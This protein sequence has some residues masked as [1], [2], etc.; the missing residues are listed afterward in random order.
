IA[1]RLEL[2]RIQA[3]GGRGAGER[4]VD[5]EHADPYEKA[6]GM[7]AA[8]WAL[9]HAREKFV[10]ANGCARHEARRPGCT[11]ADDYVMRR[12]FVRIDSVASFAARRIECRAGR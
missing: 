10:A 9:R 12:P 6:R 4:L 5:G 11:R 2:T 3:A 8:G 7:R 1:Q